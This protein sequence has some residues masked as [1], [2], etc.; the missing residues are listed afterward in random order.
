MVCAFSFAAVCAS[1]GVATRR[2]FVLPN[3]FAFNSDVFKAI[4]CLPLI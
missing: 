3:N 2:L 4:Y 1:C